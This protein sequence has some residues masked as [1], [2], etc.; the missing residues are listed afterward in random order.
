MFL[1]PYDFFRKIF[2]LNKC[3]T[4]FQRSEKVIREL[5]KAARTGTST[6][7]AAEILAFHF[8]FSCFYNLCV[9]FSFCLRVCEYEN[10][11]A[12]LLKLHED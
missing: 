2:F 3:F 8:P 1:I 12:L 6:K 5:L 11:E 7:T 9:S 10:L 4:G